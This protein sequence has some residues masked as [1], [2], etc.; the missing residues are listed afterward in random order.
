LRTNWSPVDREQRSGCNGGSGQALFASTV[1][2]TP[3]KPA[4]PTCRFE[5]KREDERRPP[6]GSRKRTVVDAGEN[7]ARENVYEVRFVRTVNAS[8]R[9]NTTMAGHCVLKLEDFM[10]VYQGTSPDDAS[11]AAVEGTHWAEHETISAA[12][13]LAAKE[14]GEVRRGSRAAR[15]GAAATAT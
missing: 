9:W 6:S 10:I 3:I 13:V 12:I 8:E 5:W 15:I 14:A 11:A 4:R 7:A 1:V 2:D